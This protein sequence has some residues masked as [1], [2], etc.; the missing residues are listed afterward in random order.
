MCGI[1]G[2][3]GQFPR[4]FDA[5][6][7]MGRYLHHRGP[8]GWGEWGDDDVVLGH[9]RLAIL[10]LLGGAQPM[11]C[12]AG[13]HVIVFNGEIYNFRELRHDIVAAGGLLRTDHSD[14][15]AIV[16]GYRVWGRNVVER[17]NGMFAFALWSLDTRRLLLARDRV[18]I[19]PLYYGR[20]AAGIFAFASEPKAL[21]GSGVIAPE[22]EPAVLHDYFL[23]R[24]ARQPRTMFRGVSS[25]EP[26][27]T[28]EFDLAADTVST[29]SF[30]TAHAVTASAGRHAD[31]DSMRHAIDSAVATHLV[32][33]VEVGVFLSGGVDSSIIAAT[34]APLAR[35]RAFTVSIAGDL[36]ELPYARKVADHVGIELHSR[37]V[38]P[39]DMLGALDAWAYFNDDPVADPSALAL[40]LLA[41]DARSHGLKVMLSGEGAD[42]LF[43]GYRA[44]LRFLAARSITARSARLGTALAGHGDPALRE[45]LAS[46][47]LRY[48]GTAH[49]TTDAMR[50]KLLL[51]ARAPE[52]NDDLAATEA[53]WGPLRSA[54]LRDQRY[55]LPADVLMRTD[56]ATMAHS[57]EA[58]VP[59]L[60]N[61]VLAESMRLSDADL[62]RLLPPA[63]KP[64]L[65]R[66]AA[67]LVPPDV[68]YRRKRGF[69]LPVAQWLVADFSERVTAML[70]ERVIP[71]LHY[72]TLIEWHA[73]LRA[74]EHR[75]AAALWAWFVLELWYRRWIRQPAT[76]R[77]TCLAPSQQ[78]ESLPVTGPAESRWRDATA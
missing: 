38:S 40:M 72:P 43:G 39:Q 15:E 24:A 9:N 41:G 48:Q 77:V 11:A 74:G 60:A 47:T 21:V 62:C 3:V 75:V 35:V 7:T 2:I 36:D 23:W 67:T 61:E 69:D 32:A 31:L 68:V 70:K 49:V 45:Y 73:S 76:P 44:Y 34:A 66:L 33:D 17:L 14:T 26:G 16:E 63:N 6:R 71:G 59:M 42:E 27:C 64:L 65:K 8:D 55:R 54:M 19:K 13:R 58:R 78:T 22:F 37:R 28:L 5:L 29:R 10:D 12:A 18:G 20:P 57:I 52:L 25:L 30:V 51:D 4:A 50:R 53:A 56:R 1:S 46:A